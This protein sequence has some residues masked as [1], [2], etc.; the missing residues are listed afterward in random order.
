MPVICPAIFLAAEPP[1]WK[2]QAPLSIPP[3]PTTAVTDSGSA[4]YP[5]HHPKDLF[6]ARIQ[7]LGIG[8]QMQR[9]PQRLRHRTLHFFPAAPRSRAIAAVRLPFNNL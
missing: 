1:L 9:L 6:H 8:N 2:T 4:V 5:Q 3:K 7:V